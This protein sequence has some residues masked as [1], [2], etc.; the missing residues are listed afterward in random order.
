ML[1]ETVQN[2]ESKL[3]QDSQEEI[4]AKSGLE[5]RVYNAPATLTVVERGKLGEESIEN[6]INWFEEFLM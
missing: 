6:F 1:L 4:L 2:K 5:R 3:R